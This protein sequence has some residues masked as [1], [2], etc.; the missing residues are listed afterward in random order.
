MRAAAL[1]AGA[2]AVLASVWAGAARA[3]FYQSTG[4]FP[5]SACRKVGSSGTLSISSHG[6]IYNDTPAGGANL[7]VD[8][9]VAS[10]SQGYS[11][12]GSQ[13]PVWYVDNSTAAIS[14]ALRMEDPDGTSVSWASASSTG[15]NSDNRSL[16]FPS[17]PGFVGGHAHM[18][19]TIPPK[20]TGNNASYIT[21]YTFNG[22]DGINDPMGNLGAHTFTGSF[23]RQIGTNGVLGVTADGTVYNDAAFG[24]SPMVVDCPLM[25]TRAQVG[26][27]VGKTKVWFLDT[28][29]M[30]VFCTL[31]AED[32]NGNATSSATLTSFAV[33][34]NHYRV[35][36]FGS[37][38]DVTTFADGF[39]HFR[40]SIPARDSGGLPSHIV[41]YGLEVDI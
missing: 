28:S 1:V 29:P 2:A 7:T 24:N 31:A 22:D 3:E 33:D 10:T 19:C 39:V 34:D 15:D 38:T 13:D 41:G 40:C 16:T 12:G 26:P 9:P 11:M 14:C 17:V 8:C 35:M 21:G 32:T 27:V 37:F 18:R 25:T 36:D 4:D 5:G 30:A 23:C 20:D 6:A